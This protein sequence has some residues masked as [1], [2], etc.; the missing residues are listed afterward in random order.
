[1][2]VRILPVPPTIEESRMSEKKV[3]ATNGGIGFAGL[4]GILFI[5]LKLTGVINWSWWYV[6]MPLYIVPAVFFSIAAMLGVVW[7]FFKII[8]GVKK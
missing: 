8:E 1:M 6:L 2:R 3:V 4:L 7:V 5:A